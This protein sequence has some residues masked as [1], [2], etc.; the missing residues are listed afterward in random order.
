MWHDPLY[1]AVLKE[2]YFKQLADWPLV[3]SSY[4]SM[5]HSSS[6]PGI[7]SNG[8]GS[9]TSFHAGSSLGTTR[10]CDGERKPTVCCMYCGSRNHVYHCCPGMGTT[11]LHKAEDGIWW[12]VEG[13]TYCINH[14]GPCPCPCKDTCSHLHACSLCFS[15]DHAAQSC[16]L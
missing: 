6:A 11:K 1:Q 5:G 8:A 12:D 9:T 16:S 2:Y 14:N 10:S 13:H 4:A 15:G 7:S 3:K